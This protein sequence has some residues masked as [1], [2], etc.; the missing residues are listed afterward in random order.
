MADKKIS[1]LPYLPQSGITSVDIIPLVTYYSAVTGDTV[2][3]RV[4]DL[5]NYILTG[6]T[7][8]SGTSGTNGSSGV[9][10]TSGTNG[11]S[12]ANGFTYPIWP[13]R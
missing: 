3:V 12:G 6:S 11:T 4:G 7:G 13:Y 10:G 1:Q 2:H 5:Q 9:N 8:S